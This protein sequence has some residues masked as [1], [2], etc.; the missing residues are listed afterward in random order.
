VSPH[1]IVFC[2]TASQP[3]VCLST[4]GAALARPMGLFDDN[5]ENNILSKALGITDLK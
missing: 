2:V 5:A 1:C 4:I 3:S